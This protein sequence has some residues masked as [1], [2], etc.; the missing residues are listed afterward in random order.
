LS[1]V[2]TVLG[3]IFISCAALQ[4]LQYFIMCIYMTVE[5]INNTKIILKTS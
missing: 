5:I 2:E 3:D 1:V 4:N